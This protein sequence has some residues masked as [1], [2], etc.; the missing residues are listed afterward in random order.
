MRII[1]NNSYFLQCFLY[2]V[3]YFFQERCEMTEKRR[4]FVL[5]IFESDNCHTANA[6]VEKAC[7]TFDLLCILTSFKNYEIFI[8]Q[9]LESKK[10]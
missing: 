3:Q 7:S 2:V 8:K 10:Q 9:I 1:F 5:E 6:E 4:I